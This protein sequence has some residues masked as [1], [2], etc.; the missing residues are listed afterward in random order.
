MPDKL[1]HVG[2][3]VKDIDEVAN[4]YKDILGINPWD[5]GVI[6]DKEHGVK[7]LLL[8]VTVEPTTL[9]TLIFGALSEFVPNTVAVTV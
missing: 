8:K 4:L 7:L 6:E 5:R 2:F 1:D 9:V 3:V